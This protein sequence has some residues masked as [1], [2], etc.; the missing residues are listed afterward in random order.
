MRLETALEQRLE[1][2]LK[3]APQIIQSIEILQLPLLEL[4]K[5]IKQELEENP[6]L[7][8][9]EEKDAPEKRE[10]MEEPAAKETTLEKTKDD[11]Q[12]EKL[13]DLEDDYPDYF[14][15]AQGPP[16]S[17]L[18]KDKKM[19]AMQNTAAKPPTLQDY[20][21]QQFNLKVRDDR[22]RTAAERIIYN[23]DGN[24][25]LRYGLEEIFDFTSG[26]VSR[27]TAEAILSEIQS[28]DPPGVGARN[29]TEC[30]LLQLDPSDEKFVIKEKLIRNHLDDIRKNRLP[31]IAKELGKSLDEVKDLLEELAKLN[32]RPGSLFANESAQYILPDVVVEQVDGEFKVRLQDQYVPSL[33]ISKMYRKLLRDKKKDPKTREFIKKKIEAAKWL[34]EA[35]EQRQ[36]TLNRVS[37]KIFEHQRSFLEHGI[38]H[39]NPLKMQRIANSLD[40]HVSTVSRAI[41]DKYV[42]T[43]RG[44]Y[45]LKFFFTGGTSTSLGERISRTSV[46][47]KVKE[48]I[49]NE[50]R[51]AP[52]SDEEIADT[53]RKEGLNIARRTVTKYRKMMKI[54]SSRQRKT[55]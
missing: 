19:E 52:L 5:L 29:T 38:S 17:V 43:D 41:A 45:P 44:I 1:Q 3:L 22:E 9:R 46:Q 40:I 8:M 51:S 49:D 4:D 13:L 24:G 15:H 36:S 33:R 34:I 6:V 32:P 14:S 39:L 55:Y 7:E 42:Q 21:F 12:F 11:E 23:I 48:I 2:K 16:K 47:N 27:E 10:G 31:K 18:E 25:Y 37:E 30:L 28:L 26:T 20:L 53:L 54:P 50:D 35:I